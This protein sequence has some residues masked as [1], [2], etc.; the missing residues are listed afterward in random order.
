MVVG[1]SNSDDDLV[2]YILGGMGWE[3]ELV[4]VNL[5]SKDSITLIEAQ[6]LLQI[7]VQT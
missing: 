6:F 1:H 4:I 7:R 2:L 5:T 3:Y